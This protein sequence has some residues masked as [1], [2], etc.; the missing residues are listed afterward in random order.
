M[1]YTYLKE[2]ILVAQDLS[3]WRISSL[4]KEG[5]LICQTGSQGLHVNLPDQL[6]QRESTWQD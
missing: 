4:D 6:H 3:F 5:L 1:K 2:Q